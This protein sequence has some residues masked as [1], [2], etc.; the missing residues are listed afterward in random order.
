MG[1]AC[2]P[3]FASG[4]PKLSP[5]VP[6]ST[7]NADTPRGPSAPVRAITTYTSDAAAPEMNCLTPS[8]T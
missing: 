2:Q 8:S 6:F 3:I 1:W 5:G 4:A 7:M